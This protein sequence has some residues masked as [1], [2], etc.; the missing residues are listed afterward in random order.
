[1]NSRRRKRFLPG[2]PG[3]EFLEDRCLPSGTAVPPPSASASVTLSTFTLNPTSAVPSV[4]NSVLGTVTLSAAAPAGGAVIPIASSDLNAAFVPG[5]SVT[6]PAGAT[7]VTFLVALGGTASKSVT[8]SASFGGVTKTALL[9]LGPAAPPP[10]SPTPSLSSVFVN[11]T[12]MVGGNIFSLQNL[13]NL[14]ISLSA[15]PL[16]PAVVTLSSSD[17][18]AATVPASVTFLPGFI[19]TLGAF[20]T[21]FPVTVSTTVTISASFGG[22]TKTALLTV[23]A[24]PT[25]TIPYVFIDP[26]IVGSLQRPI[27]THCVPAGECFNGFLALFNKPFNQDFTVGLSS[28]NPL[29]ATVPATMTVRSGATLGYFKVFPLSVNAVTTATIT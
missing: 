25:V 12:S 13:A 29:A 20:V 9:T 28:S 3:I 26:S 10:P 19:P 6:V 5:G 16:A 7:N 1:M 2:V 21:T 24:P 15:A 27:F 14:G 23:L 22:V 11:P 17:P 4:G 18:A 8:L